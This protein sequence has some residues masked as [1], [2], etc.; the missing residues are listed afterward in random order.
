[1]LPKQDRISPRT[2]KE[3]EQKYNLGT[4]LES[5]KENYAEA[6]KGDAATNKLRI[7]YLHILSEYVIIDKNLYRYK[8]LSIKGRCG[9][10]WRKRNCPRWF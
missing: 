5:G 4:V 8:Y 9:P 7:K 10:E 3:I 2:A 6:K 1:M